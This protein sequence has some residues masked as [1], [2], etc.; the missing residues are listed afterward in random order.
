MF[1]NAAVSLSIAIIFH[2]QAG[3]LV[4]TEDYTEEAF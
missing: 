1:T 4:E 2:T 3:S